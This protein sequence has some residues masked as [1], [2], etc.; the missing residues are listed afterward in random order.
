ME[1][2]LCRSRLE[3]V[4]EQV[5]TLLQR[6]NSNA[7]AVDV[8]CDEA[9]VVDPKLHRNDLEAVDRPTL[10]HESSGSNDEHMKPADD[11]H[12]QPAPTR[13][14]LHDVALTLGVEVAA[15]TSS[16]LLTSLISR[17][18]GA[19]ALSE[20]LLLRRVLSWVVSGT[21][22]GL[23]TGLPRFVAHA[24]GQREANNGHGQEESEYF[25]AASVCMIPNAIFLAL[26]MVYC[27][28]AFAQL[29]FGNHQETGL[30]MALALLL[31]GFAIHRVVYGYYRGLLEMERANL[32]E[33]CN[34]TLLPLAVI[35][36]LFRTQPIGAMMFAVG[37]LMTVIG[38]MFAIPIVGHLRK[39][40]QPRNIGA[41]CKELMKFGIPRVPGDFGAAALTA[42]GPMLAAH[43]MKIAKVSPLLL[44][45]NMLMVTGYAAGPLGVVL[46]SKVSM[47]LGRNK[48]NELHA[49]LRLLVVAVM[50]VSVLTCIQLA[51]FADVIVR[52]W[53]GP[54]FANEMGVIRMVLMAIPPYLFFVALRST[55]DAATVKPANTTN[56][57]VSLSV[58][59][60]LIGSWIA[61]FHAHS[62][63]V[64]IAGSLLAS[65]VLLAILTARTFRR[66]YGLAIPWRR[67][68][69]S[70]AVAFVLGT[71]AFALHWLHSGPVPAIEAIGAELTLTTIYLVVLGKRGSDWISYMWNVGVRRRADW[72][73]NIVQP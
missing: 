58:C 44:G 64:A 20:Y 53:V 16:L 54:A 42:L 33:L 2:V 48:H 70:F 39:L 18:L 24:A 72:P 37:G 65:Q 30:V 57:L 3:L 73:A 7:G 43:Y 13:L 60:G 29:M 22:L 31:V 61:L 25:L 6:E 27:R 40:S 34:A 23:A 21:M 66:F 50:E 36:A 1:R 55:I 56:V 49:R 26:L 14:F 19:R 11:A 45:L 59:L 32:L 41:R 38:A 9:Q 71:V 62:L 46:L 12:H 51:I 4:D 8:L 10:D 52:V 35:L 5:R 67:L 17:W 63:L 15:V 69:P 28:G 68:M 47:M